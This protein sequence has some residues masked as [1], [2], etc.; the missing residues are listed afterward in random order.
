M[1]N[2]SSNG[3]SGYDWRDD[4]YLDFLDD[5]PELEGGDYGYAIICSLPPLEDISHSPSDEAS[6]RVHAKDTPEEGLAVQR[7]PKRYRSPAGLHATPPSNR[8]PEK[9]NLNDEL[10]VQR[11][12]KRYRLPDGLHATPPSSSA[13]PSGRTPIVAGLTGSDTQYDGSAGGVSTGPSSIGM[14]VPVNG[15][16]PGGLGIVASAGGEP[17]KRCLACVSSGNQECGTKLVSFKICD[18][19]RAWNSLYPDRTR[20]CVYFKIPD[21][22]LFREGPTDTYL[23]T[24]RFLEARLDDIST[25]QTSESYPVWLTQRVGTSK[26]QVSA[27]MLLP[28]ATDVLSYT[29]ST[30]EGK[31]TLRCPPY[32]LGNMQAVL[33]ELKRHIEANEARHLAESTSR[34]PLLIHRTFLIV[35]HAMDNP[36]RSLNERLLLRNVM[37]FWTASRLIEKQ[38]YATGLEQ[39]GH[40]VESFHLLWSPESPYGGR[41]PISPI[42][43]TQFDTL[44]IKFILEPLKLFIQADLQKLVD[45]PDLKSWFTVF[46]CCFVLLN[47]Y[48]EATV[49]DWEFARRYSLDTPFSNYPML[50][51]FHAGAKTLLTY[52]HHGCKEHVP[53]TIDWSDQLDVDRANLDSVELE[54]VKNLP[55][56]MENQETLRGIRQNKKYESGFYFTMQLFESE[57]T[58][59]VSL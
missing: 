33:G 12:P 18:S 29:W 5:L 24:K 20:L 53:Y 7:A 48:D 32:A 11:A 16:R 9:D 52:F 46:L 30:S 19:C 31:R 2:P 36:K 39:L 47:S 10:A 26:I 40:S 13:A 21:I 44:V 58:P 37:Q 38:W 14:S 35:M 43:A 23:W 8:V 57:W 45:N 3:G 51:Q 56:W 59:T 50:A 25:W 55:L 49:H 15:G 6:N 42:M 17:R 27:R 41:V 28:D 4:S 22:L 1:D 54:Y 34:R